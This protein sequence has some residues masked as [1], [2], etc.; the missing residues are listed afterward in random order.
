MMSVILVFLMLTMMYDADEISL[1][2]I[3]HVAGQ[4]SFGDQ[5]NVVIHNLTNNPNMADVPDWDGLES[6]FYGI[7]EAFRRAGKRLRVNRK[8]ILET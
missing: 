2:A 5:F 1:A 7:V 4:C 8:T 6:A 3:R